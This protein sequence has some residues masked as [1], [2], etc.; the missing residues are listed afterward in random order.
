MAGLQ[1]SCRQGHG[2]SMKEGLF[3]ESQE[4]K[5]KE[6]LRKFQGGK[7]CTLFVVVC[8]EFQFTPSK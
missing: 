4:R 2:I 8:Q 5:E 3:Q 1:G 7:I 6:P